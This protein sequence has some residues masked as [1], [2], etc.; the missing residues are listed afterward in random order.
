M[1]VEKRSDQ[2]PPDQLNDQMGKINFLDLLRIWLMTDHYY[3]P[4][5]EMAEYIA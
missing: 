3:G 1:N 4:I 5:A 2:L